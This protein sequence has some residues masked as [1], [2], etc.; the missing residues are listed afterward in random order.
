MK[1]KVIRAFYDL[2]DP[3]RTIYQIGSMFEGEPKRVQELETK[4]FVKKISSGR[5]TKDELIEE[6]KE[7]KTNPEL[8]EI[9][10]KKPHTRKTKRGEHA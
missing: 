4:G 1:A 3:A 6:I 9:L 10:D 5:P 8:A 7:T 2:H